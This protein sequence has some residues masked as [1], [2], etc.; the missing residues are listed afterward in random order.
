MYRGSRPRIL[1]IIIAI[2]VI[3]LI[4][5]GL[6]SIGR[7]VLFPSSGSDKEKKE[8]GTSQST[9][10]DE[11]LK[12]DSDRSVRYTVRGSLV[13]D[14]KF[15]SYQIIVSPTER[16]VTEYQGYLDKVTESRNFGNSQTAYDEFVHAL[17]KT[18]ISK[19]REVKDNDLRGVCATNGRLYVFETFQA[20]KATN[21]IWTSTCSGSQG[22]MTA[23]IDQVHALFVNQIPDFKPMFDKVY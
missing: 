6:V 14:E 18:D 21:T 20:S 23:K 5:A 12:T 13:A 16:R 22:T 3:A 11:L 19:T 17:D 7:L 8:Q 10:K 1:P 9:L 4:I 2:I 15:R